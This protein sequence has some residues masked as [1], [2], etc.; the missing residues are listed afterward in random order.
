MATL[1]FTAVGNLLGGPLGGAIG[2]LAGRQVDQA[3]F[4]GN[5]QG[6]RLKD[7][8]VTASTY[9]EAVP[10]HFGKMRVPGTII[11]ATDLVEH[12]RTS[13]GKGR[14]SVTTYTYTASF[15]VALASRPIQGI[16]RIWADGNLLRGAGGDLK[17]SGQL[18]IYTGEYD[19]PADPFIKQVEGEALCPAFRGIAY[20]MF[21]DLDLGDFYNRVP[22]LTFEVFA[23]DGMLSVQ[24]ILEGALEEFD[25]DLALPGIDGFSCEGPIS[26]TLSMLDPLFPMDCDASS[27]VLVIARE[28]LQ[29]EAIALPEA[30]I[31][32]ED[33]SFGGRSGYTRRREP[34][35]PAPPE[36]LRYYDIARDYQPGMQRAGGR[37]Q[38]GQPKIVE[39]PAALTAENARMLADKMARQSGW[40]RE[41]LAWRT[42]ELDPVAGPG[43]LVTVPDQTGQ[44]RVSDWEWR[45]KGVEL[46]LKRVVA[47]NI[48]TAAAGA[49]TPADPGRTILPADTPAPAT[50]LAAAELPWDGTGGADSPAI[51]AA[52]SST[53]SN[54]AGAALYV[55]HGDGNL[56]PLG[57]SG[58][59]RATIGAAIDAL[60]PA[61]PL[62]FDRSAT[63]T[64]ELLATD[65]TL[66]DS[67]AHQM[68]MG[69]NR[70]LLGGEL[71]QF[72]RAVL[73][74]NRRWRLEGLLRGRGGT[75]AA[76]SEHATGECFILLDGTPV[77]L[78]PAKVGTA[79]GTLIAATG[80]GD[81]AP[82]VS[83]IAQQG[84]TLRPLSPVHGHSI[85]A[86]NGS[87]ELTWTRR[88]RGGWAW[89]DG[90]DVPLRE[91]DETYVITFGPVAAP[92]A[93]WEV[94]QPMLVLDAATLS[95]LAGSSP[96]ESFRVRQQGTYA[97]SEPLLLTTLP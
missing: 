87:M 71:I 44:W 74:G 73:L 30:A 29:S 2:A 61:N 21:Q 82:V 88:A 8:A 9:G 28:R 52:V 78:D 81:T 58:R 92:V 7:L 14:P 49:D 10:H 89:L 34:V 63:V 17:A 39:L 79:D 69:A 19:Q 90:V 70:A 51:V 77:A 76:I 53:G 65:M 20:V 54:W 1:V 75:E 26:E 84:I 35:P 91:Q 56:L 27:D 83:A 86:G 97:L 3:L 47:T 22:T 25:A 13:G 11:W 46:T 66:T 36:V 80:R 96:G 6:P 18:R 68:A 60:P 45:D 40:S 85:V 57:T 38:P 50:V 41:T 23:D 42:T 4:G 16:G 72:A 32:V 12:S 59:S 48:E 24:S 37:A 64:V 5:V 33:G 43:A 93:T 67:T 95:N 31:S 55:D 94:T 15:A 62:L